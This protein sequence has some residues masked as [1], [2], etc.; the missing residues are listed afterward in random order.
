MSD[1]KITK[2]RQEVRLTLADGSDA[3]ARR[4]EVTL[5]K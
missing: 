4:V 3:E 5:F 2:T 1:Q